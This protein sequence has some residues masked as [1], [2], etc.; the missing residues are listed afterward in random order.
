MADAKK[1]LSTSDVAKALKIDAK[2][3][4]KLLR[5]KASKANEGKRYEFRESDLPKLREMIAAHQQ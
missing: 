4:R 2:Q 3:F 5:S 1:V